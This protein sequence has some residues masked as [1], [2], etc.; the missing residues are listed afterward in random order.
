MHS[1]FARYINDART[2]LISKTF[3]WLIENCVMWYVSFVICAHRNI[4][5]VNIRCLFY[6]ANCL[7]YHH[8]YKHHFITGDLSYNHGG[9]Q[10]L[11]VSRTDIMGKRTFGQWSTKTHT[12]QGHTTFIF[13]HIWRYRRQ[14][15]FISLVWIW[16][17]SGPINEEIHLVHEIHMSPCCYWFRNMINVITLI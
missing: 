9:Y 13:I 2:T 1:A 16:Y 6:I 8:R 14:S 7:F 11:L 15:N 10:C 3:L 12:I 17:I 4:F 5:S